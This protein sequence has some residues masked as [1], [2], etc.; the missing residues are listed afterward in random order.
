MTKPLMTNPVDKVRRSWGDTAPAWVMAMA[1]ECQ[2]SSQA[3][4]AKQ[5]GWSA[6]TVSLVLGCTYTGD[7]SGVEE[8][9]KSAFEGAL[10]PCPALGGITSQECRDWRKRSQHFV[11]SNTRSGLMFRACNTCPRNQKEAAE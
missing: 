8:A 4:V 5:M 11:A 7:L 2:T 10:V 9:F 3:R 6:A 1:E